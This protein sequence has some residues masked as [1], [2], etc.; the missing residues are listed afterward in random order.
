MAFGRPGRFSRWFLVPALCVAVAG[1][2][3]TTL[4]DGSATTAL[5]VPGRAGKLVVRTPEGHRLHIG[6]NS[7]L[8]FLLHDGSWTEQVDGRDVCVNEEV[9][10]RCAGDGV[11]GLALPWADVEGV[12]VDNFDGLKTFGAVVLVTALVAVVVVVVILGAKGGGGGGG[13]GGHLGGGG[14]GGGHL[15]AGGGGHGFSG[16]GHGY[17]S[18]AHAASE[19]LMR[20]DHLNGDLLV[21]ASDGDDDRRPAQVAPLPLEQAA[22]PLRI[23]PLFRRPLRQRALRGDLWEATRGQR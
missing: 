15:A 22:P 2:R 13:G 8:R 16:G 21:H 20:A 14:G 6:E 12:E 23:L 19:S 1:C 3:T 10:A 18:W 9:V 5:R 7:R 4:L 17:G 11:E